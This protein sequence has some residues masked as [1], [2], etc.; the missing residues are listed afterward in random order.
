MFMQGV[1]GR[2]ATGLPVGLHNDG[3]PIPASAQGQ[4][5]RKFSRLAAPPEKKKIKGTGLGL[6][7][8]KQ[9]VEKHGGRIWVEAGRDGNTFVFTVAETEAEN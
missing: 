8:T 2:G 3:E 6:F 5:F 1:I 9:I 7:I 4:L